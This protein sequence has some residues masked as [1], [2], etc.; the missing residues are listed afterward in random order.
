MIDDGVVVGGTV[1]DMLTSDGFAHQIRAYHLELL[2]T[3]LGT[4]RLANNTFKL[5]TGRGR[6]AGAP[7]ASIANARRAIYRG[8]AVS[9]RNEPAEFDADGNILAIEEEF[10]AGS[11]NI[12]RREGYVD[13]EPYWAPGTTVRVCAYD[14]QENEFGTNPQGRPVPCRQAVAPDCGCGPNLRSCFT[15]QTEQNVLRAMVEQTLEFSVRTVTEDHPYTDVITGH[16]FR[17]NGPLVHYYKYQSSA[18]P[19]FV[20]ASSDRKRLPTWIYRYRLGTG[21]RRPI[22]SLRCTD[23]PWVSV[24]ISVQPSSSKSLLRS[25]S[26]QVIRCARGG[27]TRK[28]G[29]L[30]RRARPRQTMRLRILP[31]SG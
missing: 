9:C 20:A 6:N 30:Q 10:P 18:A 17:V 23:T 13:V 5:A 11:G 22:R 4:Q 14:A 3:S 7:L 26:L 28:Y 19:N 8:G 12:V 1:E 24:E 15:G 29:P 25:L 2:W 16:G 27:L 21:V 31:S